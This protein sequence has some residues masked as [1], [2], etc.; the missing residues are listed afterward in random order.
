MDEFVDLN[1]IRPA[2][3][4]CSGFKERQGYTQPQS[5]RGRLAWPAAQTQIRSLRPQHNRI[6][7]DRVGEIQAIYLPC[8]TPG[9]TN[10]RHMANFSPHT[11]RTSC[12][13]G[14][15]QRGAQIGPK[16]D[17]IVAIQLEAAYQ[18]GARVLGVDNPD[19]LGCSE[20]ATNI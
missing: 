9:R 20:G 19:V 16:P 6:E 4:P 11:L 17:R 14:R 8:I 2:Q 5:H 1:Q 12:D 18:Y 13:G 10:S 3:L 15:V 7:H